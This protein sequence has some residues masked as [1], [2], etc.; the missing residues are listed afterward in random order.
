MKTI[1]LFTSVAAICIGCLNATPLAVELIPESRMGVRGRVKIEEVTWNC[2]NEW[3]GKKAEVCRAVERAPDPKPII[4]Q[5]E[6][7]GMARKKTWDHTEGGKPGDGTICYEGKGALEI[8]MVNPNT[9]YRCFYLRR[10]DGYERDGNLLPILK[11]LPS[12][13][14]AVETCRE[15]MKKLGIDENDFARAPHRPG[16]FYVSFYNLGVG[17]TDP[18]TGNPVTK[19]FAMRLNFSQQIGKFPSFWHGNSGCIQ[20]TLADGGEF[21]S[22]EGIIR[23]WEPMGEFELLSRDEITEAIKSGF[24]WA[25]ASPS[26][27]RLRIDRVSLEA[28]HADSDVAQKHFPLIYQLS[29]RPADQPVNDGEAEVISIP[30]LKIHR[31]TYGALK[32]KPQPPTPRHP[33]GYEAPTPAARQDEKK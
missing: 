20:F 28:Y 5:A 21:A 12:K 26:S 6:A 24:Y 4:A 14:K 10:A 17:Y 22:M 7:H 31:D 2:D 16:G 3:F 9:G 33:P 19:P 1:P 8:A 30:A 32:T 11:G 29:V 23:P 25:Q 27:S 18:A 13:E 15:W